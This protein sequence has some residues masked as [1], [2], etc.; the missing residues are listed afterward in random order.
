MIF[1]IHIP[2]DSEQ[3]SVARKIRAMLDR[4]EVY[5]ST[6][7]PQDAQIGIRFHKVP[8]QELLSQIFGLI[9]RGGYEIQQV[10]PANAKATGP[11]SSPQREQKTNQS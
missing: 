10:A 1:R 3:I 5:S 4:A 8:S 11:D 7:E 6:Y 9:Q 2:K